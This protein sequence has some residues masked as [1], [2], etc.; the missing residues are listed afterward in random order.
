MTTPSRT[1]SRCGYTSE[2]LIE[3][4]TACCART[5]WMPSN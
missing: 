1:R 4:M 5:V 2:S 3:F